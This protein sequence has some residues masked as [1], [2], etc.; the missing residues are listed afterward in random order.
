MDLLFSIS[1]KYNVKYTHVKILA[2]ALITHGYMYLFRVGSWYD[3]DREVHCLLGLNTFTF[4]RSQA[5]G[6]ILNIERRCMHV[7]YTISILKAFSN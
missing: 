5:V 4:M 1:Y 6:K 3:N 7:F 2:L